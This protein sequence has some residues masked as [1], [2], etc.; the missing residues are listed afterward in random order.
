MARHKHAELIIAWA[1]GEQIEYEQRPG[2]WTPV[3]KYP[4]WEEDTA[5]RVRPKP[6]T[7]MTDQ[8]LRNIYYHSGGSDHFEVSLRSVADTAI[9]HYVKEQEKNNAETQA[10]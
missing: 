2:V 5:Y 9:Q 1:E 10:R 6:V 3:A 8:E 7:S 4:L